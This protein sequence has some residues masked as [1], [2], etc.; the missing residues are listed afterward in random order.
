VGGGG[1]SRAL[2]RGWEA[3]EAAVDGE[4]ELRRRSGEV[5]SLGKEMAVEMQ[6]RES[7][8]ECVGS[9]RMCSGSRRRFGR[10]GAGVV[11][12]AGGMVAQ[13][14]VAR[15]GEARRRPARGGERWRERWGSTWRRGKRRGGSRS[16]AHGRRGRRG[17]AEKKKHRRRTGGRR[18]GT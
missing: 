17:R 8:S 9:F 5:E 10:A 7:K 2:D 16:S 4:Q 14:A 12:P 18:R 11:R 13:A 6:T 15:R 3:A 1:V